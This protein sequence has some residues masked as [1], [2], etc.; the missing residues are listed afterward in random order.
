MLFTV[1]LITLSCNMLDR[2][3]AKLKLQSIFCQHLKVYKLY[4]SIINAKRSS[5][6]YQ[7]LDYENKKNKLTFWYIMYDIFCIYGDL[8][9]CLWHLHSSDE[10]HISYANPSNHLG[11]RD[12][13]I[14]I[15]IMLVG[16]IS[17][18]F[19]LCAVPFRSL[20]CFWSWTKPYSSILSATAILC[21]FGVIPLPLSASYDQL[22]FSSHCITHFPL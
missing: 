16:E 10:F 3:C 6:W 12:I 22:L 8:T 14:N 17:H 11:S 4:I 13:C 1:I 7:S 5:I 15:Y 9:W 21:S 2:W 18:C 20:L 19:L